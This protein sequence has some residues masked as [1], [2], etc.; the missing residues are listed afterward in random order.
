MKKT[1]HGDHEIRLRFPVFKNY[2]IWIIFTDDMV[3]SRMS[4]YSTAGA[5]GE[6][7]TMA[8]VSS[9]SLGCHIFLKTKAEAGIIA[10]E[11][12]HTTMRLLNWAEAKDFDEEVIAYHLTYIVD[13]AVDLQAKILGVQSSKAGETDANQSSIAQGSDGSVQRLQ[14]RFDKEG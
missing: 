14:S 8:F 12:Y 1:R 13:R 2:S 3:K 10:H 5:A 4:R 6:E 7:G 11:A 9:C